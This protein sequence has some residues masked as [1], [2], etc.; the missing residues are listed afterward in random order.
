[1]IP[2]RT[3]K[4]FLECRDVL[5]MKNTKC[6]VYQQHTQHRPF[7]QIVLP[8]APSMIRFLYLFLTILNHKPKCCKL[9]SKTS[10]M[11]TEEVHFFLDF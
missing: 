5:I 3:I 11:I 1:M 7:T 4:A 6:L 10:Q 8:A 2:I 9:P